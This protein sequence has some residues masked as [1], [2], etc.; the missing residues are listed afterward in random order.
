MFQNLIESGSHRKDIARRG[1]FLLGTLALYSA[2]VATA[3]VASVYAYNARLDAQNYEVTMLPSWALPA[4]T[5]TIVHNDPP[6][7]AG[8][9]NTSEVSIRKQLVLDLNTTSHTPPP[10]STQASNVLPMPPGLVKLGNVDRNASL[11][12][13]P[14]QIG[15]GGDGGPVVS[16]SRAQVVIATDDPR[17]PE[18]IKPTHAPTQQKPLALSQLIASKVLS[19][20]VPPYPAIAKATNVQGTVTVEILVDEQGRVVNATAKEGPLMLREAAR[21]A[22]LLARFTPTKLNGEPVKVSGVIS[23]NFMLR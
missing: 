2:L 5:H 10:I 23:Y 11:I 15:P 17:P 22:A 20:P 3:G 7:H 21:Q 16:N 14:S 1:R 4:T 13:G 19:K 12:G 9:A 8:H 6:T 18:A